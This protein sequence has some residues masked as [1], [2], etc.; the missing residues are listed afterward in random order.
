MLP[1]KAASSLEKTSS[2]RGAMVW[3]GLNR[4][5]SSLD[6]SFCLL[7]CMRSKRHFLF[8]VL[9]LSGG[10]PDYTAQGGSEAPCIHCYSWA[11]W[12]EMKTPFRGG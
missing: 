2:Q 4:G 6:F 3:G 1:D 12:K 5:A 8:E 10:W 7:L 9:S 11:G